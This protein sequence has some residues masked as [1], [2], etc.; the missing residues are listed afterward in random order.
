MVILRIYE[1]PTS[2]EPTTTM[3]IDPNN[4]TIDGI[5]INTLLEAYGRSHKSSSSYGQ[6]IFPTGNNHD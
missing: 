2:E 6:S 3:H 4:T 1:T 5:S